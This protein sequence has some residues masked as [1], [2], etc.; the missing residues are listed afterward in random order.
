MRNIPPKTDNTSVLP[1]ADFNSMNDEMRTII[2]SGS[3][4]IGGPDNQ[5]SKS[6]SNY[7]G[8]A[9]YYNE[10][11]GT[12]DAIT[13]VIANVNL[14]PTEYFDGLRVRFIGSVANSGDPSGVTVTVGNLGLQ[15]IKQFNGAALEAGAIVQ[16]EMTELLFVF[17]LGHFI[18]ASSSNTRMITGD[19]T[20]V[21]ANS[22]GQFTTLNAAYESI[23]D[24]YILDNVVVTIE[25]EGSITETEPT[26]VSHSEANN[27]KIIGE[28]AITVDISSVNSVSGGAGDFDVDYDISAPLTGIVVGDYV[29]I[30]DTVSSGPEIF[31]EYGRKHEGVW[32]VVATTPTSVEVKNKFGF[33]MSDALKTS[34]LS[35]GKITFLKSRLNYGVAGNGLEIKNTV[36]NTLSD[37]LVINTA[38]VGA[39]AFVMRNAHMSVDNKFFGVVSET[40][41]AINMVNSSISEAGTIAAI[42]DEP[43]RDTI[44]M[45]DCIVNGIGSM[46]ANGGAG[47]V[48]IALDNCSLH[49]NNLIACGNATA[50]PPTQRGPTAILVDLKSNVEMVLVVTVANSR[51]GLVVSGTSEAR[52][53]SVVSADNDIGVVVINN[54]MFTTLERVDIVDNKRAGDK[55]GLDIGRGASVDLSAGTERLLITGN[56]TDDVIIGGNAHLS[57]SATGPTRTIGTLRARLVSSASITGITVTTLIPPIQFSFVEVIP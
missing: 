4:V 25:I 50:S 55:F 57:A 52:L 9:D 5:L 1:A 7:V 23:R 3:E 47:F 28:A 56:T 16:N 2:T 49:G 53:F 26:I 22:G 19:T 42:G 51:L 39:T 14:Q 45:R 27:I 38:G 8:M 30:H 37:F 15:T 24:Q 44:D 48:A 40:Q 18:I 17:S 6:M 13:L 35:A 20:I 36:L 54:A 12:P 21:V 10:Q 43:T 46:I 33:A 29:I 31:K 41:G 32:K 34:D 11:A